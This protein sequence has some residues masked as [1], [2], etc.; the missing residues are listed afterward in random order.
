METEHRQLMRRAREQVEADFQ[1]AMSARRAE[2]MREITDQQAA[3]QAQAA[4][5]I[6]DATE[7]TNRIVAE[8]Q[9]RAERLDERRQQTAAALRA[10]GQLLAD[11]EPLLASLPGETLLKETVPDEPEPGRSG[12]TRSLSP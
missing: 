3:A 6:R 1:I 10:V 12:A 9:Q 7:R 5:L 8:A 4:Q 2:A 11:V